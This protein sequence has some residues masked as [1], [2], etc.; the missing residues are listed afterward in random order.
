MA[1]P[2]TSEVTR[3]WAGDRVLSRIFSLGGGEAGGKDNN[4]IIE[5]AVQ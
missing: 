2:I 3:D 5:V 1:V 4:I